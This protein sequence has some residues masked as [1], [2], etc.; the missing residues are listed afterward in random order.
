MENMC[1]AC[2]IYP[3]LAAKQS[4]NKLEQIEIKQLTELTT[5]RLRGSVCHVTM[6]PLVTAKCVQP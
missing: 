2:K 5:G 1:V 4:N 6:S 3:R